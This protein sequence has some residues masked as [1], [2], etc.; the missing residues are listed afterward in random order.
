ML[1]EDTAPLVEEEP[2]VVAEESQ[3]EGFLAGVDR[4]KP[5]EEL[6]VVEEQ[7]Y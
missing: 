7:P 4:Q 1:L 6:L 3:T 5:L 2:F